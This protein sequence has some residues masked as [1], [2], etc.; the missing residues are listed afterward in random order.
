MGKPEA[1]APL[2]QRSGA[3]GGKAARKSAK[4]R[5]STRMNEPRVLQYLDEHFSEANCASTIENPLQR[6]ADTTFFSSDTMPY[7]LPTSNPPADLL[8]SDN[9]YGYSSITGCAPA[10]PIDPLFYESLEK[11]SDS[12]L[13]C[14]SFC[15]SEDSLLNCGLGCM[16]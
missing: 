7:Y 4:M 2:R 6:A 9:P 16:S 8:V 5:R 11:C 12:M 14:D 15:D 13:S 10:S 1:P 3:K